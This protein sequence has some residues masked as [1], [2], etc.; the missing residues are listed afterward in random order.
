M[1]DTSRIAIVTGANRGLGRSTALALA[2]GGVDSIIT[3]RANAEEAE[4]VAAGVAER[5]ATAVA[6]RLDTRETS[7]FPAF[8]AEVTEALGRWGRSDFDYLV[9][10]A[11]SS[12]AASFEE[13]TE[14]QLDEM[15]EVHFKGVFLLTQKLLPLI[16]DGGRIVNL[17]TGLTRFSG[18]GTI[19]YASAKGAVDVFTRQLASELGPR[20]ITVNAIA[21]G[22]I[23]TDFNGGAMRDDEQLR[24]LLASGAALGRVGEPDDIGPAVAALLGD[25]NRWVTGQRLEASGGTYL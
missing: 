8:A 18:P 25:A 2:A 4:Q 1:N 15:I 14:E 16:A 11:G 6:L 13:T 5:G 3:Y 22:P 9:N 7:S 20:G 12:A 17:S 10:N 24:E 23:G 21:P 19:A